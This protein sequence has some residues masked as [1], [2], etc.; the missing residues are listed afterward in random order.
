M[1]PNLK[2]KLKIFRKNHYQS[3]G[4]IKGSLK[5][6][7]DSSSDD[8]EETVYATLQRGLVKYVTKYHT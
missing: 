1:Q 2:Y 5:L 4:I 7:L 3:E 6:L 8:F